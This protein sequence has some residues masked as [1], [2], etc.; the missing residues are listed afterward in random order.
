MISSIKCSRCWV[1]LGFGP[2][3]VVPIEEDL[4]LDILPCGHEWSV[5]VEP[6]V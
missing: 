1:W 5:G 6:R 2:H 3:S 4:I